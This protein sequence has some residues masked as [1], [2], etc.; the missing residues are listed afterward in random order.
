MNFQQMFENITSLENI[1]VG[2]ILK[3]NKFGKGEVVK[4]DGNILKID[5]FES[6]VKKILFDPKYFNLEP[7]NF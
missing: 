2:D 3:H 5:F 7:N 6:D 4:V 1:K